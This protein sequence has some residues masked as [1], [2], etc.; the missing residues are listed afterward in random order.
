MSGQ[1]AWALQLFRRSVLKQQ[2]WNAIA[3]MLGPTTG[4]RC[5]DVGSDN[6][7]ISLLLRRRGGAWVS[8][9]LDEQSVAAI[10]SLVGS[11]VVQLTGGRMPFQ[12]AEFDRVVLVDCLEHVHDDQGFMREILRAT[13]PGGEIICN[14]PL[15]KDSWLR[16]V[17]AAIGQTDEAHG[18]VR[19]GY[20]PEELAGLVGAGG[21]LVA[22]RTYS[23]FCSQAVDTLMTWAI[24]R[25][26]KGRGGASAKGTIVTR[27]DLAAHRT[28]LACYTLAY[29]FLWV[30]AQCDRLLWFRQGYMLLAKVLVA[31]VRAPAA[32]G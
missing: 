22:H 9:D 5:L 32:V 15:R 31:P 13:K 27:E 29:P 24:R 21:E 19:P 14:V 4:L 3:A 20:R 18:H 17:R 26:Q 16:R 28:L 7:V 8:A 25:T 12:D 11:D 30:I 1:T 6:G 10:R 23:R 2:K